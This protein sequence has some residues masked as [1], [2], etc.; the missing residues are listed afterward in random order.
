M[1]P[2]EETYDQLYETAIQMC[3][4]RGIEQ[5]EVSNFATPGNES[6]HNIQYWKSRDYVGIGP[7]AHSRLTVNGSRKALV[8]VMQPEQW[9]SHVHSTNDELLLGTIKTEEILQQHRFEEFFLM[10]LRLTQEGVSENALLYHTGNSFDVLNRNVLQ[11]LIDGR[12]LTIKKQDQD[13]VMTATHK[14]IKI[15]DSLLATLL[16]N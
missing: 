15:L 3:K 16:V 9:M 13:R 2:S 11:Q 14:G 12:F 4:E 5:Y 7:G 6:Q 8:Q 1:L 10:G